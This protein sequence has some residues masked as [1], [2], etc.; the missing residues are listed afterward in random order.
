[1]IALVAGEIEGGALTN[2]RPFRAPHHSASIRP[3]SG[4][5][6]ARGPGRSRSPTTARC[7][8]TSLP[9]FQ[10]PAL[11]GRLNE[12]LEAA[13][14]ANSDADVFAITATL[15]GAGASIMQAT[16][17]NASDGKPGEGSV[18]TTT[19]RIQTPSGAVIEFEFG[20]EWK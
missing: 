18:S 15:A 8:S 2:R 4:A 1:M 17:P 19:Q 16:K 7:S 14:K 5:A 11:D 12:A 9:E 6:C 10:P 3:W 20:N 13:K